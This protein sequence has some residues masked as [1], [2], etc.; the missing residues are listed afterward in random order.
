MWVVQYLLFNEYSALVVNFIGIARNAVYLLG[1]KN[2][3]AESKLVPLF[4]ILLFVTFGIITYETPIDVLPVLA[5]CFSSITF[6]LKEEQAIRVLSFF[7]VIPWLIFSAHV[8]SIGGVISEVFNT[9]SIV[10]AICRFKKHSTIKFG[11]NS[12]SQKS[13]A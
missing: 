1:H 2:K 13:K 5:M 8:G 9:V 10:V 4:A 12:L 7:V 11:E 6:F 3:I